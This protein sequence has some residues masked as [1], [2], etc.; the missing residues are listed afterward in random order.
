MF[1]PQMQTLA[2]GISRIFIII[3]L[4]SQCVSVWDMACWWYVSQNVCLT[5][6]MVVDENLCVCTW[7][8]IFCVYCW[9]ERSGVVSTK[10]LI[11]V[12][13]NIVLLSWCIDY[14]L[15]RLDFRRSSR[16]WRWCFSWES[17]DRYLFRSCN[18]HSRTLSVRIPPL[19]MWWVCVKTIVWMLSA[20]VV[21]WL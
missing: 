3:W 6:D 2:E 5:H 1:G 15:G 4:I 7:S 8:V 11:C 18:V 20:H 16:P 17:W 12:T 21:Y 10:G 14:L 19:D 9:T 13:V